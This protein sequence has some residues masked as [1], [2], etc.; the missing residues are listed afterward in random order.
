MFSAES[1]VT[2]IRLTGYFDE[3]ELLDAIRQNSVDGDFW[4][5]HDGQGN[6]IAYYFTPKKGIGIRDYA[7]A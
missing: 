1:E 2:G 7:L 4:D 6:G 5:V 3:D